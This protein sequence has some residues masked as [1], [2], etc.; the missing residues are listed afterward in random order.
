MSKHTK[1]KHVDDATFEINRVKH[2][3]GFRYQLNDGSYITD[4]KKLIRLKKLVIPPMWTDVLISQWEDGHVQATGRDK[5][6]R[7]QYIY[8]SEWEK[9]RQQEK[10]DKMLDFAQKLPAIRDHC[11]ALLSTPGWS[12]DKVLA[13]IVSILDQT[14]IRIGNQRYT[15]ENESYGLTTLRRKHLDESSDA[16]IFNYKGKS[17]QE[18][19]VTI[20][21]DALVSFI[22]TVA[23]QPG[24]EIFRYQESANQWQTIDSEDVNEFIHSI[25]GDQF[26]SKDFRTWVA[27]RLAVEKYPEAIAHKTENPRKKMTNILLRAVADEIGN[28]PAV[29]KDYYVHPAIMQLI[30][31]KALPKIDDFHADKSAHGLSAAEKIVLRILKKSQ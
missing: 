20:D 2:G 3:R 26:Y 29:C 30:D 24:Y 13:L 23:E 22:K 28:T 18:R 17:H 1:I 16:L 12:K 5:K 19:A 15:D 4:N 14:G 27:T 10:F 8:H 21:D 6:G 11:G 25:A 9:Q 31:K 7:K